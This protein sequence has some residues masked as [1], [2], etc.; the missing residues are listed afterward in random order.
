MQL[1][2]KPG[3]AISFSEET[4]ASDLGGW[5]EHQ[6]ETQA[7]CVQ[8]K[9]SHFVVST[10]L[11]SVQFPQRKSDFLYLCPLRDSCY[12][13]ANSISKEGHSSLLQQKSVHLL[14]YVWLDK[15]LFS[16]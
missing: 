16:F 1:Q 9:L 6:P 8:S 11:M 7:Q 5:R 3:S 4:E 2:R 12:V 15:Y 14:H 13:T 10:C